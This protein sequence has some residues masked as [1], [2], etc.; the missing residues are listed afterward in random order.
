LSRDRT[1]FWQRWGINERFI[2]GKPGNSMLER[3]RLIQTPLF[4]LY[5]HFLFREDL[6]RDP[7][8]H[9]WSFWSLVLR[10]GYHEELT[11]D[12]RV[13]DRKIIG[14]RAGSVHHF[15]LRSAHR[16]SSVLSGTVTLVLVGRRRR[17]W[18]FYTPEGWVDYRKYDRPSPY[19]PTRGRV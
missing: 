10:G 1:K 8:D 2:I 13:G 18:G 11:P 6:D 4:G 3:W 14:R 15:P 19:I 16:I 7:H 5:V 9:P 17:S 12:P